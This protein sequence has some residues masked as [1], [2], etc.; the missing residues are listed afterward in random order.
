V[1]PLLSGLLLAVAIAPADA[2]AQVVFDNPVN[3]SATD[4]GAFSQNNQQLTSRFSLAS[5]TSVVGASWFGTM[6]SRDPLNTGD[7]WAFNVT[8]RSATAGAPGGVVG[9]RSLLAQV[10]ET[11][12][13]IADERLYRFDAT[14]AGF[15][16]SASTDYFFSTTNSGTQ[17]T[18]RWTQ[19]TVSAPS[20]I[21]QNGGSTWT[22]WTEEGRTPVNFTLRGST[23]VVPE[24]STFLLLASAVPLVVGVARRRRR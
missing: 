21:S 3:L 18:F 19:G 13:F 2:R 10:T 11:D 7:S 24:P 14:F 6:F 12:V 8:I 1:L 9:V 5:A 15:D 22:D 4:A 17:S 16:L 23:T 20:F